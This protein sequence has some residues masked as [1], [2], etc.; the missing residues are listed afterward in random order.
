MMSGP[1][2]IAVEPDGVCELCGIVAAVWTRGSERV[3]RLWHEGRKSSA[4]GDGITRI[5]GISAMNNTAQKCG[6]RKAGNGASGDGA[7]GRG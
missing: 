3:F 7:G 1:G 6:K 2:F 4:A 5:R